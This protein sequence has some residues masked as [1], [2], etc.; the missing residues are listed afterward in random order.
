[1]ES[2]YCTH[3]NTLKNINKNLFTINAILNFNYGS[4]Y[5]FTH[6]LLLKYCGCVHRGLSQPNFTFVKQKKQPIVP[7]KN[8]VIQYK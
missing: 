2:M 6:L 3:T 7:H 8:D 4:Y 5:F 1:M